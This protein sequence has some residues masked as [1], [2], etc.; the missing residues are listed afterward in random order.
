MPSLPPYASM[1][2]LHRAFIPY[3]ASIPALPL[4][5]VPAVAVH[6]FKYSIH[7]KRPGTNL[8]PCCSS[9]SHWAVDAP[10]CLCAC[11]FEILIDDIC[12]CLSDFNPSLLL[13][14]FPHTTIPVLPSYRRPEVLSDEDLRSM[15]RN[16]HPEAERTP[17]GFYKNLSVLSR[18]DPFT[19]ETRGSPAVVATASGGAPATASE[20]EGSTQAPTPAS[21]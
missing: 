10:A 6:C 20:L 14:S 3:A 8:L 1:L 21:G 2:P 12:R 5:V 15:I 9:T 13:Q 16:W 7:M 18:V 11:P 19:G 17:K 4:Y